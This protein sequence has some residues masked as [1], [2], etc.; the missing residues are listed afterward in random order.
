[1]AFG[2]ACATV[3]TTAI[4]LPVVYWR[5]DEKM[6]R[7]AFLWWT[8]CVH[9]G[10]FGGHWARVSPHVKGYKYPLLT[11]LPHLFYTLSL[12]FIFDNRKNTFSLFLFFKSIKLG[13]GGKRKS[14]SK[15]ED[16]STTQHREDFSTHSC[17]SFLLI[18]I[19]LYHDLCCIS[20]SYFFVHDHGSLNPLLW[21]RDV[22]SWRIF[23]ISMNGNDVF[24]AIS[25]VCIGLI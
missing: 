21:L 15:F 24:H 19:I 3:F 9:L 6:R 7:L 12:I 14:T 23:V 22:N 17:L 11:I 5:R 4:T 1:M 8:R 20:L 18:F 10:N 2:V 25:C 13:F 16:F